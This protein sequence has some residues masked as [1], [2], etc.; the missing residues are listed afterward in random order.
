M[1]NQNVP[2][3]SQEA[4]LLNNKELQQQYIAQVG[5]ANG[6]LVVKGH[7]FTEV[8]EGKSVNYEQLLQ[9]YMTIGFQATHFARA[10]ET[11]NQMLHFR[12]DPLQKQPNGEEEDEDIRKYKEAHTNPYV[13][14]SK[15]TIFL[16]YTSNMI[17][18]GVRETIKFL[19]KHKLVNCIVTTC[20]GIEEDFMKCLHDTYVGDFELK[21]MEMR[22]HGVNRIGNLLVPNENYVTFEQFLLP[23][24]DQMLQEQVTQGVSWTP[25]KIIQRLGKEINHEDS[26]Y[27][28][29]YKNNIPVFCPGLTD[30]SIGDMMYFHSYKQDTKL[31]VDILQ[32]LR[33]LNDIAVESTKTGMLILGGG[34]VKHH[35]CNANLMRNGADFTVYINTGHEF[36]GSDSGARPDEAVSW[37]KIKGD[38]K[39]VKICADA[40]LIFPLLVAQT[41]AKYVQEQKK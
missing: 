22:K 34:I 24:L 10:V 32:D 6:T 11:V 1:S 26:V 36:D 28:W 33:K 35:I 14:R 20:G 9:S 31:I 17:S 21:G 23:I 18:C 4:V 2:T 40:T 15:C 27:Y 37:G 7:S 5:Q 29:C 8:E 3:I 30:G 12:A 39:P 25:S 38:S 19:V 41:F 13:D 16:G